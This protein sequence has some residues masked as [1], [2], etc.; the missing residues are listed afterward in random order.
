MQTEV[1]HIPPWLLS[2][3]VL[4]L[5]LLCLWL[6]TIYRRYQSRRALG[7]LKEGSGALQNAMLT[8]LGLFL[9]F[10]FGMTVSKFESR[11]EAIVEEANDIGTAILR[12][13]LYPDSVRSELRNYF[14]QYVQTRIAYY[15]AGS[16]EQMIQ[17]TMDEGANYTGMIWNKVVAQSHD[18][19]NSVRSMQMIPAVNA[20]IDTAGARE[21]ERNSHVPRLILLTLLLLT[22]TGSFLIGYD[23]PRT[24][25]SSIFVVGF[26]IMITLTIY[27][28]LELDRP[29]IGLI[30]LHSAEKMIE[31]LLKMLPR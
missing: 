31:D 2:L 18:P 5:I 8:L 14:K 10:T 22:I 11:R 1:L 13:D 6:G 25:R 29:R 9:A 19:A 30:N 16:N 3:F 24:D 23:Q 28:I 7:E 15:Q 4:F 27:L 26:A 17:A 20:V 12:C 21:A